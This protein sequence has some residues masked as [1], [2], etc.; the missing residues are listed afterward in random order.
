M[1]VHAW[2][3]WENAS[4]FDHLYRA[5]RVVPQPT[6][7]DMHRMPIINVLSSTRGLYSSKY[8]VLFLTGY[9]EGRACRQ[10]ENR[11]PDA[12]NIGGLL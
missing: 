10:P 2:V 4:L 9:A 7:G 5:L 8:T 3:Y 6:I 1:L 11:Q 12:Y